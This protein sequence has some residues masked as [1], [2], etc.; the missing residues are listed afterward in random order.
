MLTTDKM[1]PA[2]DK[3]LPPR[4]V[5]RE[6]MPSMMEMGAVITLR[7]QQHISTMLQIP[8]TRD[9]MAKPFRS[10]GTGCWGCMDCQLLGY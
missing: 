5:A 4:C 9:A 6:M 8:S 1:M 10:S 2:M 3:P 7:Q